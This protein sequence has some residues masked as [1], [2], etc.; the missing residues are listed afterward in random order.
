MINTANED[1]FTEIGSRFVYREA[2]RETGKPDDVTRNVY[3]AKPIKPNQHLC[4]AL[5][6]IS[7]GF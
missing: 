3:K 4:V 7:F 2:M 1:N 6:Q 5:V